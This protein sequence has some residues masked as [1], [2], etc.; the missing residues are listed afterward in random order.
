MD[1]HADD[2]IGPID[3][4]GEKPNSHAI[5]EE[6]RFDLC[7]PKLLRFVQLKIILRCLLRLL[8]SARRR[9]YCQRRFQTA[10]SL[11]KIKI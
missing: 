3:M 4:I 11:I 1:R 10:P 9:V 2:D 7:N 8:T 5:L 6:C